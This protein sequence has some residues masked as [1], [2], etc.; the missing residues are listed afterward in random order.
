MFR[1][2]PFSVML[3]RSSCDGASP[4][5]MSR[6]ARQALSFNRP[7][8]RGTVLNVWGFYHFNSLLTGFNLAPVCHCQ[9]ERGTGGSTTSATAGQ[10]LVACDVA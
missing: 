4:A 2:L 7:A 3:V 10:L 5:R 8:V 1:T 9:G 6:K